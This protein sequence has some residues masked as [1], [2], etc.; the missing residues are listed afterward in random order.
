L[1]PVN[2]KFAWAQASVTKSLIIKKSVWHI[3]LNRN[4]ENFNHRGYAT[5][6]SR[7]GLLYP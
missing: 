2:I 5:I 6:H 1:H 4:L 3:I 7:L